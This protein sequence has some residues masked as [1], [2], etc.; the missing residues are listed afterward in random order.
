MIRF[1]G[2]NVNKSI[3]GMKWRQPMMQVDMISSL[4]SLLEL[5][6]KALSAEGLRRE[7]KAA[8]VEARQ[9]KILAGINGA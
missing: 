5:Q 4:A 8:I 7:A 9:L 3:G 6:S 2:S 1:F